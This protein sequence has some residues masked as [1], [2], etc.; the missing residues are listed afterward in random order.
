MYFEDVLTFLQ[1]SINPYL[2]VETLQI[3]LSNQSNVYYHMFVQIA[4]G[5]GCIST[6]VAFVW[7]F[8]A[9]FYQ[10]CFQTASPKGGIVT[11]VT[12]GQKFETADNWE[13]GNFVISLSTYVIIW[14]LK[15][16]IL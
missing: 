2:F 10:M 8:R 13:N 6:L 5:G 7:L 11:M 9:V 1:S 4:L 14:I 12:L 15:T 16:C 3:F